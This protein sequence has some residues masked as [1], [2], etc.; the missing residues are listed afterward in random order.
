LAAHAMSH[1]PIVQDAEPWFVLQAFMQTPQLETLEA[2]STSHPF[3]FMPSQFANVPSQPTTWQVPVAHDS[4]A[5]LSAQG[6]P[7]PPQLAFV[8]RL[9]S[10]PLAGLPSQFS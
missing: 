6:T 4:V 10:Q 8:C 2:V 5:L 9:T 7:H 3:P 1:V